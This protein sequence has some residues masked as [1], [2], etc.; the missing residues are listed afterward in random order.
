MKQLVEINGTH[1]LAKLSFWS[2][3]F[4]SYAQKDL[5]WQALQ[6]DVNVELLQS[7]LSSTCKAYYEKSQFSRNKNTAENNFGNICQSIYP[8]RF[9]FCIILFDF[10]V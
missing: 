10:F 1:I 6:Y 5:G 3:F 4:K 8:N 9:S 2:W 7:L